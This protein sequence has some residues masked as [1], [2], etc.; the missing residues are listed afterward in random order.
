MKSSVSHGKES[1]PQ[2]L[3]KL[4]ELQKWLKQWI[5]VIQIFAS[6][7]IVIVSNVTQFFMRSF[8]STS[9]PFSG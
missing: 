8:T 3:P 9:L 7:N 4:R 1:G 5:K 2:L 6:I